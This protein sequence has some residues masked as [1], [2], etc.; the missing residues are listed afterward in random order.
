MRELRRNKDFMSSLDAG[1]SAERK[2]DEAH[3]HIMHDDAA[4]REKLKSMGKV[5]KR[6]FAQ[7]ARLFQRTG[8]AMAT[9]AKGGKFKHINP[10]PSRDKLLLGDEPTSDGEEPETPKPKNAL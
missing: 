2:A 1:P 9:G 10:L 5:S 8:G 6:K 4:F 7:M 3:A